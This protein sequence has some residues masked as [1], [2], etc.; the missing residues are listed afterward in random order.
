ML[1]LGVL[2]KNWR[3]NSTAFSGS[4]TIIEISRREQAPCS[5]PSLCQYLGGI[6]LGKEINSLQRF[7]LSMTKGV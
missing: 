4:R 5:S 1:I 6:Q 2:I 7:G 3:L